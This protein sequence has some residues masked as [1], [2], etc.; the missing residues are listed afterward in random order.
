MRNYPQ[1][2]RRFQSQERENTWL[3]W[4]LKSIINVANHHIDLS[5]THTWSQIPKPKKKIKQSI[6]FPFLLL[7]LNHPIHQSSQFNRIIT[8]TSFH[9]H[10]HPSMVKK[11]VPDWL[12]S[13]LWSTPQPP[14]PTA[15]SK[16]YPSDPITD[17]PLPIPPPAPSTSS[18]DHGKAE[19]RDPLSSTG[20][21]NYAT[22]ITTT[23][24]NHYYSDDENGSSSANSTT[25]A[26]GAGVHSIA[27]SP[28]PPLVAEDISR[29]AQ[30]LQE[31]YFTLTQF[32]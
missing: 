16:P 15:T 22:N 24:A 23:V 26:S 18:V 5:H 14:S 19:V 13:S 17:P 2:L 28:S 10:F 31:V 27:P 4:K 7:R 9:F 32:V 11:S 29:K 30:I 6:N 3:T 8:L 25:S 21:S 12:N 20:T 1:F